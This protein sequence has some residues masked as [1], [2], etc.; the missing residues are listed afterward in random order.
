MS[1]ETEVKLLTLLN[2]SAVKRPRELDLPGGHR[3][4]PTASPT[5]NGTK[6]TNA[7]GQVGARK[8]KKSVGFAGIVGPRENSK[9]A[10]IE[11][12]G[13]G[14][15]KAKGNTLNGVRDLNGKANGGKVNGHAESTAS[16]DG[17]VVDEDESA[18]EDGAS[19][20]QGDQFKSL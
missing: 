1:S 13:K 20:G 18:D 2:V 15:A 8:R 14:K 7:H 19:S 10:Q 3:G 6:N 4:S 11:G 9:A 12:K 16:V 17:F 5:P